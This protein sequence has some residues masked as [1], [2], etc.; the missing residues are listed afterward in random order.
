[1]LFAR[2]LF[3][4]LLAQKGP[5]LA[6]LVVTAL[7][8]MLFVSSAGAYRDLRDSYAHT[9][10][11]LALAGLRAD[12]AR[13]D[14]A[15][16]SRAAAIPGV[17]AAEARM[18]VEVPVSPP[19]GPSL[20]AALRVLSLPDAGEPALDRLLLIEGALPADGEVLLEKHFAQHHKLGRG[21]KIRL[22]DGAGD[23]VVSGVAVSAEYLWVARDEN[24]FMPGPGEFGVGWMRRA[25]LRRV[26][27]ALLARGGA[28]AESPAL[29]AAAGDAAGDQL[30]VQPAPGADVAA[31]SSALGRMFGA[32]RAPHITRSDDLVGVKL[33]QMDVDGYRGMAILFPFFFL[34]V[35]SFIVGSA[36]ARMVDAER[37]VI[38]TLLALGVG[39]ARILGHYLAHGVALGG[40]GALAGALLG[41]AASPALTREYAGEL[42]IPFV[43]A[44]VHLDLL[45]VGLTVG[46]AVSA[47]AALSPAIRAMRL[48]PAA[49]MRPAR[50]SLG[51]AARLARRL[52]LPLPL[53]LATRDV[54]GRPVRSL[55]TAL[56][57]AAAVV[58]VLAT[59]ALLDS[60]TTTF[61]ATFREARRYD[62]RVDFGGPA[63]TEEIR[64]AAAAQPDV[65]VVEPILVLPATIEARGAQSEVLLQA[66]DDDAAL[67]RSVDVDRSPRPPGVGGI[68]LTRASAKKLGVA[69]GD[70]VRVRPPAPGDAVSLRV[71]G[72]ADA[73]M[74]STASVRRADVAPAWH[75]GGMSTAVLL[76]TAPGRSA[77]VRSALAEALPGAV[78]VEDSASTRVQ[79]DAMMG[80]GWVMLAAMLGFA[81]V[82]AAAILFNTATLSVIERR[83]EL[84]TLRAL[85]LTMREITA[86]VTIELSLQAIVGMA[87]GLPLAALASKAMLRAFSSDLFSMPFVISPV[88]VGVTI[89]SVIVVVLIAQWPAL[90][91]IGRASLADAVRVREG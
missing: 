3:R 34:G 82:L 60:M 10:A 9:R 56:G 45:V 20:R 8:V 44:K 81:G 91:Q 39:R 61:S 65:R 30:L 66:L 14:P 59:G 53:K 29:L 41:L 76:S 49:A 77:A 63:P 78:R 80:L 86:V 47:L 58:L 6:V 4:D 50:P 19:G 52:P 13:V 25:P 18:V 27:S 40:A 84:A 46:L 2:K 90:R 73:V 68:A 69:I 28:A 38:G 35:G 16:V 83:R 57:V 24:D 51:P 12:A 75:L 15:D 22:G 7:G 79:F 87:A 72:F 36:L 85:G 23:L 71:T 26:A 55:G 37:P 89:A 62:V 88:T 48:S 67:L 70:E 54:L 33:L 5:S 21:A 74:G 31:V 17:A 1:M 43:E 11:R 64:R 42:S 32:D